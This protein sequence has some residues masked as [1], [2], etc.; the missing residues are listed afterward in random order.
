[1]NK[2]ISS[3]SLPY[4]RKLSKIKKG[5][6]NYLLCLDGSGCSLPLNYK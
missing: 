2:I 5:D 6:R 1:M 3:I 4:K